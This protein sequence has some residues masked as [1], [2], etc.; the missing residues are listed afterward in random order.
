MTAYKIIATFVET[1]SRLENN[2]KSSTRDVLLKVKES[3]K[4]ASNL[5]FERVKL[6]IMADILQNPDLRRFLE[7]S[8][9]GS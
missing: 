4:K 3:G 6:E 5:V 8:R 1:G 9:R 7:L 2:M